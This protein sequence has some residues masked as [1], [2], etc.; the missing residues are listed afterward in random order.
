MHSEESRNYYN[1]DD[2][3]G[4]SIIETNL[5]DNLISANLQQNQRF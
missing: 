5:L 1:C 4:E 2:F 3:T